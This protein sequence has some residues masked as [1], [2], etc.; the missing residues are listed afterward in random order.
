MAVLIIWALLALAAA[1]C[2][3]AAGNAQPGSQAGTGEAAAKQQPVPGY[4]AADIVARDVNTGQQVTLASLKGRVVMLNF[5]ATWCGPCRVEMPAMEAFQ[6]EAKTDVK[7]LAVGGDSGE[8]P[9][10]LAAFAKELNLTFTV[11]HDGGA[12]ILPYRV[13]GLPTTFFID[14]NGVIR[15]R[16]S[17][18][19]TIEEMRQLA[20]D[21]SRM[22]KQ[23]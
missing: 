11:A 14:Q 12:A 15:V 10:K 21:T 17:G 4:E 22:G 19:L 18:P 13:A 5:W 23:Q 20:A 3:G 6:K 2:S 7:V 1:G 16:H 9:E 8:S